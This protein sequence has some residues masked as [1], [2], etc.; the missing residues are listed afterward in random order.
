VQVV[1]DQS[2]HTFFDHPLDHVPAMLLVEAMRQ[3]SVASAAQID[4][5]DPAQA[6][7]TRC[8]AAYGRYAEHDAAID[9]DVE[10]ERPE[11]EN[12]TVTLTAR[13]AMSQFGA[14][15]GEGELTLAFPAGA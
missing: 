10:L 12:G 9:C 15:F 3:A 13:L 11:R 6:A 1:V 4:E 7:I 2:H 5:L 8:R 14:Q